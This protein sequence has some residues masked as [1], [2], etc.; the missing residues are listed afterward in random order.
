MKPNPMFRSAND[1]A[2]DVGSSSAKHSASISSDRE[3]KAVSFVFCRSRW[4]GFRSV[5]AALLISGPWGS[6]VSRAVPARRQSPIANVLLGP[7]RRRRPRHGVAGAV[8]RNLVVAV[9]DEG[10]RRYQ[11]R[12]IAGHVTV[13]DAHGRA[14]IGA[15]ALPIGHDHARFD[16]ELARADRR[17]GDQAERR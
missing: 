7:D 5:R 10:A 12:R 3:Q 4:S 1:S 2:W 14:G 13:G 9:G 6:F 8:T 17:L 15:D 16:V 11:P